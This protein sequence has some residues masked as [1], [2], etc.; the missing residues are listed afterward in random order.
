LLQRDGTP[1]SL[2]LDWYDFL[3]ALRFHQWIRG[4]VRFSS[5]ETLLAQMELDRA[6]V[7]LHATQCKDSLG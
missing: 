6:A 5:V 3:L 2:P 7:M 1:L 4:Q